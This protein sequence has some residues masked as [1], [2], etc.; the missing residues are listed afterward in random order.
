PMLNISKYF[1]EARKSVLSAGKILKKY[2]LE[3]FKIEYKGTRNPVTAAD[4]NSEKAIIK[5]LGKKF[6]D[7]DFLCE[8]SCDSTDI[9]KGKLVWI[10]DPLDGT[11]NFIHKLPVFSISLALYDG[12]KA[13]FGIVYNPIS[14]EFFHAIENKGAYLNGKKI[15]VS[16]IND[17][18]HSLIVTGFPYDYEKRQK[19]VDEKFRKFC[20]NVEG[21][22]RLGSASVDLCYVACGRFDGFWEEGLKPWDVAAGT[23]IVKEAGG[24]ITDFVGRNNYLFGETLVASNSKIHNEM[25][26][27]TKDDSNR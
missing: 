25:I 27:I 2:Y 12:N 8:E 22:R 7:V 3:N 1:N 14:G 5:N 18:K 20:L 4:K 11:V 17:L 15:S 9:K 6:S 19:S 16:K 13:L 21:L 26:K 24:N 23:I 10:L